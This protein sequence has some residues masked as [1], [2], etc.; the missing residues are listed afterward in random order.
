MV[1]ELEDG[2]R[3]LIRVDE[4]TPNVWRT[5]PFYDDIKSWA[6]MALQNEQQ[7]ATL[8]GRKMIM[9]FPSQ[10]IDCGI[11]H[12]DEAIVTAERSDGTFSVTKIKQNDPRFS[13]LKFGVS[14]SGHPAKPV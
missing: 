3:L 8:I 7:I 4:S 13:R 2:G 11:V 1:I 10:D 9:I 14:Y 12:E 5:K 6:W